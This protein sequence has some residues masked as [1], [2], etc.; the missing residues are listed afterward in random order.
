MPFGVALGYG[1]SGFVANIS[2]SIPFW[3]ESAIMAVFA[4]LCLFIKNPSKVKKIVSPV[5]AAESDTDESDQEKL[6]EST[7]AAATASDSG[8]PSDLEIVKKKSE[9]P[10]NVFFAIKDLVCNNVYVLTVMGY[11]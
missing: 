2:W 9:K 4:F 7:S 8:R 11:V 3:M 10:K 5:K 1:I 6:M